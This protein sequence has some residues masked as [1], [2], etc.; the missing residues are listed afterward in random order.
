MLGAVASWRG[1][2]WGAAPLSDGMKTRD[3][4]R[5]SGPSRQGE[6]ITRKRSR[7]GGEKRQTPYL[8]NG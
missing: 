6:R 7:N 2:R 3:P 5:W 8:C 4:G 1:G